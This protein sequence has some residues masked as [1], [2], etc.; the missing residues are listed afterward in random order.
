MSKTKTINLFNSNEDGLNT[1]ICF[2]I[3][4]DGSINNRNVIKQEDKEKKAAYNRRWNNDNKEHH[5]EKSKQW[6]NDNR[7]YHNE[8][9]KQWKKNNLDKV[10]I[11]N[12]KYKDANPEKIA[13]SK[14]KWIDNNSEKIRI[15]A[16]RNHAKRKDWG[17][18]IPINTYFSGAHFHHLHQ[19]SKRVGMYIPAD[20]H[21][22]IRHRNDNQN[23]MELI[24]RA[25]WK[26][27]F[28]IK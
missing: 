14:Q 8:K 27:Y 9:C 20:L 25:A 11:Y 22:S 15:I 4:N 10:T 19:N 6:Y 16:Q 12:Q 21:T 18:I 1:N 13:E 28:Y 5:N 24:N 23:S 17:D 7:E 26:W 2:I 3:N